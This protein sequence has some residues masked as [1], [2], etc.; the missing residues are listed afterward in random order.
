MTRHSPYLLSVR[1][2]F[3]RPGSAPGAWS[4]SGTFPCV[5]P[6]PPRTLPRWHC[7]RQP[8][9]HTDPDTWPVYD[10]YANN[11][12]V[13]DAWVTW[14]SGGLDLEAVG[15]LKEQKYCADIDLNGV[16]DIF[17]FALLAS[18]WGSHFGG[19]GWI[20]RCDLAEPKDS[21]ID[22]AD[23]AAFAAQWLEAEKWRY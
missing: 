19:P 14:G 16:V 9:A 23:L 18:A 7:V 4:L 6:L 12:P 5:L 3:H 2:A 22:T 13:Y 21:I 17:D 20:G 11:H 1:G 8:A 10:R 15:V